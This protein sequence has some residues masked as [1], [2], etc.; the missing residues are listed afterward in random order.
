MSLIWF[1]FAIVRHIAA[2]MRRYAIGFI[3]CILSAVDLTAFT[4]GRCYNRIEN[5][6]YKQKPRVEYKLEVKKVFGW[7][8]T[9]LT[10]RLLFVLSFAAILL[11]IADPQRSDAIAVIAS[12]HSRGAWHVRRWHRTDDI[13]AIIAKTYAGVTGQN[14]YNKR[15]LPKLIPKLNHVQ[16]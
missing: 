7:S 3:E 4:L 12:E 2:E 10:T 9:A 16:H 13:T 14:T 5:R 11:V 15:L 1:V 6:N 8:W